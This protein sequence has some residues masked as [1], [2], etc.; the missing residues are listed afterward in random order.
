[1]NHVTSIGLD[2]HARSV[3]A[4]AFDLHTG[5]V[6]SKRFGNDPVEIAEWVLSFDSPKAV[7]ET[8]VTG[9][10]LCKALRALGVDCAVAAVSRLQKP[11]ANKRVK[12]DR[13]DAEML[14]RLLATHNVV[15]VFVPDDETEALQ[16]IT[17]AL[18]D[19]R[20]DLARAKQRLT[21]FLLRLGYLF[22][23]ANERGR[24]VGNWTRAHWAWIRKI[25]LK[26]PAAQET[27]DYYISEVRHFEGQK[28]AL[29]R[30][31]ER[32][33]AKDRWRGRAAALCCLKGIDVMTAACLV[34]EAGVFSRFGS[35]SAFASWLG[36]VPSEHSSGG[37]ERRGGI[38]KAGNKH[39]RR[40][41]VEAAWHYASCQPSRKAHK[42]SGEVPLNVE[43]HAHRGVLRL[44]ERRRHFHASKKKPAVANVAT[45]RELA[46]WVWAVGRMREGTLG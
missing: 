24:R 26:E 40:L 17:R 21:K 16:A 45:A 6:V 7:Y 3:S 31:V 32:H 14:A 8:G 5:E 4:A 9:F 10:A 1:M 39:A 20:E 43:N 34:A 15:E 28:K 36:L 27:L 33:V 38:T 35:A 46:G 29:E 22:D 30:M 25:E 13:A 37:S 19:A 11:A 2:V 41:L 44:I 18:A 12:N 42:W 23:E